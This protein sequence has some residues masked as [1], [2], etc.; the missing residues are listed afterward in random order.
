[1]SDNG[2]LS[3]SLTLRRGAMARVGLDRVALV[4]AVAELGSISA[5]A[6]RLG[7]SYR[8][9]WEAVQALN[10]LFDGPLIEAAPGGKSGGAANVTPRG[11]AVVAAF[12]RVQAEID[13]AMAKLEGNLA[14]EPARDLFWSLG[15]RTSARNALRGVIAHVTP[16]EVNSEVTL[17]L[18][19][20]VEI[21]AIVTRRSV[22]D[23]DLAPGK[24]AV[25]LIKSSFVIL[26]K[27]EN[28]RTSARNQIAGRVASREDGAVNSEIA[29]D[30]GGG[31]TLT[32]TITLE[33][34]KAL[35][36]AVGEPIVALIKA[37]HVI[38]AVE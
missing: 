26:A 30:I 32:A 9:A 36:I 25:A 6:A 21:T 24:P 14:G 19:D 11:K 33:S 38:L 10:N 15:M 23:L 27:G 13:A 5:A 3:A 37:P 4:E 18:G 35:A 1:M 12:R 29:V 31:K 22:Q 8:G 17:R 2:D 16:G 7:I 28:L 20:G 34:A